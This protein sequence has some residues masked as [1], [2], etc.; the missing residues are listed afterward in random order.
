LKTV[1]DEGV[2]RELAKMLRAVDCTVDEFPNSWKGMKNGALLTLIEEAGF[3]C[4]VTCDKS[5]E[6]QQ[7]LKNRKMAILVLPQKLAELELIVEVIADGIRQAKSGVVMRI[8]KRPIG[9]R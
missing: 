9:R 1:L 7:S 6:W 3:D 5:M 4:L 8:Q 2:P